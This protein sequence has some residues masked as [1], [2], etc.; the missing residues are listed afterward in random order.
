MEV[1]LGGGQVFGGVVDCNHPGL[2][3][4]RKTTQCDFVGEMIQQK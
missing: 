3:A 2:E 4:I 1:L